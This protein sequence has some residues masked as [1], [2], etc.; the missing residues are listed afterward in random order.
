M[1]PFGDKKN[2]TRELIELSRRIY[3]RGL[4]AGCGGNISVLLDEHHFLVTRSGSSLA[5][6]TESDLLTVSITGDVVAG[7]G[8]PSSEMPVHAAIYRELRPQSV[9]HTHP[10]LISALAI[11][12]TPLKP[13]IFEHSV[14]LGEVSIIP[15]QSPNIIHIEELIEPL[16]N[17]KVLVLQHHGVVAIGESLYEAF[18]L[19]DLLET[20]AKT[21]M[22]AG[23]L[24]TV[25]PLPC[26]AQRN[27]QR[28][29]KGV[30]FFAPAHAR[31]A[32]ASVNQDKDMA[33]MGRSCAFTTTMCFRAADA[34]QEWLLV[35]EQG[36]IEK[37]LTEVGTEKPAFTFTAT[38]NIWKRIISGRIPFFV[39]L[40]Q[41]RLTMEGDVRKLSAWYLPVQL[42]FECI[43]AVS[44]Q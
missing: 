43:K 9:I 44:D 23:D 19:T 4:T 30:E 40:Y 18:L 31:I 11:N 28:L 37:I 3:D 17:N 33:M 34:A 20:S 7:S 10:P 16:R 2:L 32:A 41:G 6:L 21:I 36:K 1:E 39:A 27:S 35:I 12:G 38:R 13:L 8:K 14:V 5:F 25:T 24:S 15:Q 26:V 22:A 29:P 42:L